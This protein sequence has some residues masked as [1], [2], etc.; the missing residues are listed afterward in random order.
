MTFKTFLKRLWPALLSIIG[1]IALVFGTYE[2]LE[3]YW[4]E[5]AYP[6]LIYYFHLTRGIGTS[7]LVGLILWWF[8]LK[9]DFFSLGKRALNLAE[10][11][12]S[13][14]NLESRKLFA[15]WLVRLRWVAVLLSGIAIYLSG[16]LASVI[17]TTNM[18]LTL[19]GLVTLL[20]VLNL[21]YS[22]WQQKRNSYSLILSVQIILDLLILTAML[23]YSGG[24]ENPFFLLYLFH[25]I[26]A[27]IIFRPGPAFA[28]T[29]LATVLCGTMAV[30]E[31]SGLI[32]HHTLK[33]SPQIVTSNIQI[34]VAHSSY[35]ILG[36][37]IA[38]SIVLYGTTFFTTRLMMNLR[39]TTDQLVNETNRRQ[40]LL[41]EL[42]T[43]Q[44]RERAKVGR[45]LHD[46][47]GQKLSALQMKVSQI[48]NATDGAT[49]E[50]EALKSDVEGTIDEVR[51][52]SSRI[53]PPA[54]DDCGL[55]CAIDNHI[56]EIK[57]QYEP[58]VRFEYTGLSHQTNLGHNL[59]IALYRIVQEALLNALLHSEADEISILLHHRDDEVSV[60]I[61]DDGIGFDL[62]KLM[63]EEE[64][65]Y[66]G[67]QGMQ[68]RIANLDGEFIVETE[69]GHGTQ[70]KAVIPLSENELYTNG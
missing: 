70:V 37:L 35:F 50:L 31:Y 7:L 66:L 23:H 65:E 11:D 21:F 60:L 33:L 19:F 25:V 26:M 20:A 12:S 61:E 44:E 27:S 46:Q 64:R 59:D 28:F 1:V 15:K 56:K 43:A 34:H 13:N 4:L 45:E 39:R 3:N 18:V 22:L 2:I 53:R 9:K 48:L 14:Y 69:S 24:M 8:F 36:R 47:I 55:P 16:V 6:N 62:D 68:E 58:N 67:I 17:P 29:T 57:D 42:F 10:T 32:P 38:F 49:G 30:G 41:Q 5:D 54:L 51:S 63:Q 52:L 40:K